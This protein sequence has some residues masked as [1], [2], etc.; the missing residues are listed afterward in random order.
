MLEHQVPPIVCVAVYCL[1]V[2]IFSFGSAL[3]CILKCGDIRRRNQNASDHPLVK[4]SEDR[5]RVKTK[6]L[7]ALVAM[8]A[9]TMCN[10]LCF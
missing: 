5:D 4:T 3:G 1:A 2:V 10:Q 9:L 7:S 8:T 6:T